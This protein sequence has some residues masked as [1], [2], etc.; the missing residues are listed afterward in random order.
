MIKKAVLIKRL[1]LFLKKKKKKVGSF[2]IHI[3]GSSEIDFTCTRGLNE[4]L[5]NKVVTSSTT[6]KIK[7]PKKKKKKKKY[8]FFTENIKRTSAFI[9]LFFFFSPKWLCFCI[10]CTLNLNRISFEQPGPD[11]LTLISRPAGT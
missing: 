6:N 11:K 3:F 1:P 2:S 10:K 5:T 9:Y 8:I 4:S 7:H